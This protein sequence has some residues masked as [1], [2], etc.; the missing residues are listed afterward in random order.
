M[1]DTYSSFNERGIENWRERNVREPQECFLPV[2]VVGHVGQA[3]DSTAVFHAL[4]KKRPKLEK[5]LTSQ[6]AA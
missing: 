4:N 3:L 5:S 6:F 1:C 2:T